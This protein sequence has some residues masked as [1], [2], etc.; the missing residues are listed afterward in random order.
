MVAGMASNLALIFLNSRLYGEPLAD[1]PKSLETFIAKLPKSGFLLVLLAHASQAFVGA[2]VLRLIAP[3]C[4]QGAVAGIG[5]LALLGGVVN[6]KVIPC[7]TWFAVA[8]C[9]VYLPSA[10]L[11]AFLVSKRL[12]QN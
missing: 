7:P 9:V 3:T 5:L 11:G 1:D 10:W 8:D 4:P 6:L 12:K 2:A